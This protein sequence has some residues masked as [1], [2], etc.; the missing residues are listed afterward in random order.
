MIIFSLIFMLSY[1]PGNNFDFGVHGCRIISDL[2]FTISLQVKEEKRFD[3]I[4]RI[5]RI[6]HMGWGHINLSGR[7][8]FAAQKEPPEID[9]IL[10]HLG[11][12]LPHSA[13]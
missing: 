1:L 10:S 13:F 12:F 9:T 5:D 8:E 3:L 4:E 11:G 2:L 7:F 6:S